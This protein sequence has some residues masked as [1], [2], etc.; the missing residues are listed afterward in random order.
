MLP[1]KKKY[2]GYTLFNTNGSK[3]EVVRPI[4]NTE[5]SK[6]AEYAQYDAMPEAYASTSRKSPF[7]VSTSSKVLKASTNSIPS[8]V[9][10]L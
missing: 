2:I 4:R 9:N 8:K 3:T 6:P 10:L 7:K 1:L 5:A